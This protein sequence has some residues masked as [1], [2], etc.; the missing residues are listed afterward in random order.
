VLLVANSYLLLLHYRF[1]G[2]M[3]DNCGKCVDNLIYSM[4]ICYVA[5]SMR[6]LLLYVILFML[7]IMYMTLKDMLFCSTV[8]CCVVLW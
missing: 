1:A 3:R 5:N 4:G 7:K 2:T 8:I 6:Y